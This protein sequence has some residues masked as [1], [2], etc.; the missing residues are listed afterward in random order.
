[1]AY[2]VEPAVFSSSVEAC[3]FRVKFVLMLACLA[4]QC[5]LCQMTEI[6]LPLLALL[7]HSAVDITVSVCFSRCFALL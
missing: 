2:A 3:V 5:V 7:D 6:S 1:M 4:S